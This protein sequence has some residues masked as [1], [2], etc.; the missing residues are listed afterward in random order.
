MSSILKVNEIQ[1]VSTGNTA[2]TINDSADVTFGSGI[3]DIPKQNNAFELI[4]AYNSTSNGTLTGSNTGG[5]TSAHI[6]FTNV[7]TTEY[8]QYKLVIGFYSDIHGSAHDFTFRFLTGTNTEVTTAH[9]RQSVQRSRDGGSYDVFIDDNND[10]GVIWR[11]ASV[12]TN[13]QNGGIHGE[14]TFMNLNTNTIGG[15]TAS[16]TYSGGD[17][18]AYLPITYGT[19]V[20]FAPDT[21]DY[22]RQDSFCRYNVS[23]APGYHTGFCLMGE[24]N[25]LAGTHMALY[26]LRIS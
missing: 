24:A 26:G 2:F 15:V 25:E 7:F 13:S 8:I 9:Y 20:G 21:G 23:Q 19:F 17:N 22:E 1:N 6:Y 12:G 18:T 16:R 10:R 14:M 5:G 11:N 4:R 3:V